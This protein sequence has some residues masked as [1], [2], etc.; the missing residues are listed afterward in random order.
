MLSMSCIIEVSDRHDSG[1]VELDVPEIWEAVELMVAM[2]SERQE[3]SRT[4]EQVP[5][6]WIPFVQERGM[7]GRMI[8]QPVN[9]VFEEEKF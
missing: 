6:S 8:R 9:G 5:S 7:V 3:G 2:S 1:L 4:E